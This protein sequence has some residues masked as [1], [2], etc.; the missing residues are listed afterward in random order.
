MY[1]LLRHRFANSPEGN[2]AVL[3]YNH[4]MDSLGYDI[5]VTSTNYA[6]GSAAALGN[7]IANRIIA[8]GQQDGSNEQNL[9]QNQYYQPKNGD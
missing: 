5:N 4:L 7:Y 9:Y 2:N 3:R 6:S 8:Y 1:R